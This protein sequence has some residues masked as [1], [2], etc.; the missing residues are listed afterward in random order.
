MKWQI[1][2]DHSTL[3]CFLNGSFP[4]DSGLHLQDQSLQ[5]ANFVFE[6]KFNDMH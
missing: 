5:S 3:F 4:L 2:C 6:W 1:L